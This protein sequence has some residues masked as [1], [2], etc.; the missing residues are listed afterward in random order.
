MK[1]SGSHRGSLNLAPRTGILS[2]LSPAA[3]RR[4]LRPEHLTLESD[5]ECHSRDNRYLPP[6]LRSTTATRSFWILLTSFLPMLGCH[7]APEHSED[8]LQ[9]VWKRIESRR[10]QGGEETVN[11]SLGQNLYIFTEGHYS[12]VS[13]R[14]SGP[15]AGYETPWQPSEEE[16]CARY[17]AFTVNSG[18]YEVSDSTVVI[19]PIVARAADF[20]GGTASYRY[21]IAGDTLW[22]RMVEEYSPEGIPAPW[23][24]TR[25]S[26]SKLIRLE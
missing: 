9:G 17:D 15:P 5:M 12:I 1:A 10:S 25:T 19:R 14:T 21:R 26:E 3:S 18:V 8:Q 16:K 7:F 20:V 24:G 13:L 22:L 4:A 6:H 11:T 2:R 23:V